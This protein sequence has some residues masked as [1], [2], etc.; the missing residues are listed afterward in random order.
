MV[1]LLLLVLPILLVLNFR[2]FYWRDLVHDRYLYVPSAG[3]CILAGVALLE[4]SRW[5]TKA[6]SPAVQQFLCAGLLCGLTL[7]T[8]AEAQSWRNNLSVLANAAQLAPG[9]IG[10]QIM[11]GDELESRNKFV[12]AKISYLRALQLTPQW[13]PAWFAYG[14]TLLLTGDLNG[15]IQSFHRAIALEDT[16]IEEVWLAMAMDKAG[17][18]GE[19]HALLAWA[20]AQDPSMMQ[21]ALDVEKKEIAAASAQ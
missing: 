15:A 18:H 21:A 17:Q 7:T 5:I 19:A 9:N 13:A 2:V 14:R 20:V 3:F 10:A 4:V 6:I 11:L 16:P 12:E 8:L 1:A